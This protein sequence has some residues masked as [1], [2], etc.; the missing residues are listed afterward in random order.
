MC[1]PIELSQWAD[2]QSERSR[3]WLS[4]SNRLV[5]ADRY[6]HASCLCSILARKKSGLNDQIFI[7]HYQKNKENSHAG[8][9]RKVVGQ[10]KLVEK[11]P[12]SSQVHTTHMLDGTA[13]S[14]VNTTDR[15]G[16]GRSEYVPTSTCPFTDEETK[17]RKFRS[18]NTLNR[19]TIDYHAS[20]RRNVF[21]RS[22]LLLLSLALIRDL[23]TKSKS[24]V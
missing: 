23:R 8:S 21:W 4:Y 18:S 16:I 2:C 10:R 15:L 24:C 14:Q 19:N 9:R 20:S 1:V 12:L 13:T 7:R 3:V 5:V 6:A 17:Y 22:N 11:K